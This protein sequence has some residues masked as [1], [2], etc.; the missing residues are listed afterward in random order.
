LNKEDVNHK[1]QYITH[2]E[3]EAIVIVNGLAKKKSPGLMDPL[4]NF[5]RPFKKK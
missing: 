3:I 2:D 5:T 1:N 4:L